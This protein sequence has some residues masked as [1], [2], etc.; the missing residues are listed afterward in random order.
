MDKIFTELERAIYR[1]YYIDELIDL[2]YEEYENAGE[3]KKKCKKDRFGLSYA[4]YKWRV[5]RLERLMSSLQNELNGI[6]STIIKMEHL[7]PSDT[8]LKA[9]SGK[10]VAKYSL[11]IDNK[12]LVKRINQQSET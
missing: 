1:V 4:A 9:E 3:L 5:Y 7:I 8:V 10:V 6:I 2:L 11:L 12:T